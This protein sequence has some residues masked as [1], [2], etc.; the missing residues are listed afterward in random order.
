MGQMKKVVFDF[1][2]SWVGRVLGECMQNGLDASGL[3][4]LTL[5]ETIHFQMDCVDKLSES[6]EDAMDEQTENYTKLCTEEFKAS[7]EAPA[8]LKLHVRAENKAF[9]V[10]NKL[11]KPDNERLFDDTF[12]LPHVDFERTAVASLAGGALVAMVG[13]GALL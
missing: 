13:F 4:N 1:G 8:K 2:K 3:Q 11:D 12:Q 6:L 5:A 9:R 7:E 10:D